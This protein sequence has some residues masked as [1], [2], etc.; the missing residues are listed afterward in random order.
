VLDCV[1]ANAD[2]EALQCKVDYMDI[3]EAVAFSKFLLPLAVSWMIYRIAKRVRHRG[4]RISIKTIVSVFFGCSA[5]LVLLLLLVQAGCSRRVPPIYSPDGRHVALLRYALQGALGDDYAT[6]DLRS[7]WI[8]WAETVYSGV[9]SW[10]FKNTKPLDPEVRWLD[11]AHLLIR[12]YD[13]GSGEEGR[14]AP[15]TCKNRIGD[16]Q[17]ICE[18]LRVPIAE[19]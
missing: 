12:Y 18:R 11:G 14:G 1:F 6:V 15:V 2:S 5:V 17:I 8:P 9:G 4:L 16:V 13:N 10:D 19:R 7:R 3:S